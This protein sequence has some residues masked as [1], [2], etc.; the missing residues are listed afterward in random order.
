MIFSG[1]MD[2]DERAEVVMLELAEIDECTDAEQLLAWFYDCRELAD[3]IVAQIEVNKLT[4]ARDTDWIYRASGVLIGL[5][6]KLKRIERHC[7]AS[8]FNLPD[9]KDAS[10]RNQI[11]QLLQQVREARSTERKLIVGWMRDT[12]GQQAEPVATLIEEKAHFGFR[13]STL[14]GEAA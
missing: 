12:L 2:R 7:A 10:Q 6:K 4:E 1:E 11:T 9:S 3:D 14:I 5:K 8:G 13:Q